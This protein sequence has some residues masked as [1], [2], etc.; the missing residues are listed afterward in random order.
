ML[1]NKLINKN[2]QLLSLRSK[3]F[4]EEKNKLLIKR[5]K[6]TNI[7]DGFIFKLL[8]SQKYVG[9]LDITKI[10]NEFKNKSINRTSYSQRAKI[11]TEEFL[12]EYFSFLNIELNN[13]FYN[14]KQNNILVPCIASD[15]VKSI[16][17]YS[18]KNKKCIKNKNDT[19]TFLSIGMFNITYNE[20]VLLK[21]L[22]HK[23]ERKAMTDNLITDNIPKIYVSDRGFQDQKVF[24]KINN[25]NEYFI[26]RLKGN[27]LMINKDIINDD[28]DVKTNIPNARII[29]YTINDSNYYI[30]TNIPRSMYTWETIKNI[31]HKRWDIEEYFK[32]I[33]A[34]M[35]MNSFI[36][37]D[38][39]SIKTS[40]YC[41]LIISKIVYFI[42]NIYSKKIKND[43][44]TIN[45]IALTKDIY[46]KFLI[47]FI[48]NHKFS[49]RFLIRFFK[50]AIDIISTSINK[51]NPRIGL[52]PYTKWYVK[53]YGKKYLLNEPD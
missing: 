52:L 39:N 19:F 32:Y 47:R 25:N 5:N 20:P 13:L 24:E 53:G 28:Y 41:N 6:E 43:K 21:T 42:K 16:A 10:I 49:E 22:D 29:N 11:I 27:T 38:W 17:Y 35:K 51:S 40:I 50:N 23:N 45:K 18:T 2:F 8:Y 33:K 46:N 36:E 34:T 44:T 1:S 4:L 37:R 48:F 9:H 31:Y 12:C 7:F 14:N 15:G 26:C 3:K 30:Y